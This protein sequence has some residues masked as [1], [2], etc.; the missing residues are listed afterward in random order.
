[1]NPLEPKPPDPCP[2]AP[3]FLSWNRPCPFL[4]NFWPNLPDFTTSLSC[5]RAIDTRFGSSRLGWGMLFKRSSRFAL[6]VQKFKLCSVSSTIALQR[7][8]TQVSYSRPESSLRAKDARVGNSRFDCDAT[9][10][11][12]HS[13]A[14]LWTSRLGLLNESAT[15][16][17]NLANWGL[18]FMMYSQI[19][20][21]F[22]LRLVLV[23]IP[24]PGGL[25]P[26]VFDS[27]AI[28]K[29][30]FISIEEV[31]MCVF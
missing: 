5:L 24:F 8:E 25:R 21:R 12:C 19:T 26:E 16:F 6:Q 30:C 3:S 23:A 18:L 9:Y 2:P 28:V 22:S 15:S 7:Q 14:F 31:D 29:I 27:L 4:L 20:L 1:M 11:L 17:V 13:L 10:D